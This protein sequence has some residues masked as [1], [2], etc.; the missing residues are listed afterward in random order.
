MEIGSVGVRKKYA[1]SAGI[2]ALT[3][4]EERFSPINRP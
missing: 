4:A 3:E 1:K 2:D